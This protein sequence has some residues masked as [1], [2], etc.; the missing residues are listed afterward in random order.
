MT[1]TF[2][3]LQNLFILFYYS[4]NPSK[5]LNAVCAPIGHPNTISFPVRT[6]SDIAMFPD[7]HQ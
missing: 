2:Y 5:T 7:S 6:G 4:I 3:K 1:C